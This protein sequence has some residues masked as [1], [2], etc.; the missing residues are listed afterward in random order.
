MNFE[1]TKIKEL[2]V[3]QKESFEEKKENLDMVKEILEASFG[4]DKLPKDLV[5]DMVNIRKDIRN[6]IEKEN[7]VEELDDLTDHRIKL[8]MADIY[9]PSFKNEEIK[10]ITEEADGDIEISFENGQKEKLGEG[11]KEL[12]FSL[13]VYFDSYRLALNAN[14]F[15]NNIEGIKDEIIQSNNDKKTNFYKEEEKTDEVVSKLKEKYIQAGFSEAELKELIKICD[16]KDL[17]SLPIHEINIMS[18]VNELFS[19]YMKGDKA[20]YVGLSVAL[21]AP[22]FIQGYAPM[23]L[24]NA[25]K[26]GTVDINQ[27]F[28]FALAAVGGSS[29]SFGI[30]K[31]YKDFINKNYKKEGGISEF[32]AK[33]L[34]EMPPDETKK[35]GLDTIKK[36]SERGRSSYENVLN[37]IGFDVLPTVTTLATSAVVL[38]EKS[39]I[40][41]GTTVL[42]S[43]I[44]IILNKYIEK[45]GKFWGRQRDSERA[46]EEMIK[47][48]NEQLNA[49]MEI[50]L[51]GEKE[52]FFEE[53]KEFMEKEKIAQGNSRYFEFLQDYLNG[54]TSVIN[55]TLG[56]LA[57]ALSGGSPDKVLAAILYSGNID[58]GLQRLMSSKRNLFRSLRNIMQME[59]MFNGYA[60]EEEGKEKGRIGIDQIKNGDIDLKNVNVELDSKKILDDISLNIPSGSMAYLEGA[61]G[62]GKTTLMKIISG[63]YRPTSGEVKFGEV[64]VENIKKTGEESIYNKIAYLSQFPYLFD[65]TLKN[66]LKFGL[67]KN[68]KITDDKIVEVLK[69]V[70]L[71]DRFGKN[72]DE[73]I[74]GGHGDLGKTSGGETSRI[75]LARVLLKIRNSDSKLVFLDEPTAS[76]DKTTKEE[77]AKIIN[78]EKIK[79]PET[80]FIVISHDTQFVEMLNCNI[81]VKMEKGKVIEE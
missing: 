69:D 4:K 32:T 8:L 33:N 29:I 21:M 53:I 44:T 80:T 38:Y 75:G 50:I 39:P 56:A 77:I 81:K 73:K 59:L 23:L 71:Y 2:K 58:R 24:A 51:A 78:N 22:A 17:D 14:K 26:G 74:F 20:K 5:L 47:K 68:V 66:N 18:K 1:K 49:H 40:L 3:T 48:M 31:N 19:R 36:R 42:A 43:G 10:E 72:L 62:A 37:T 11:E 9:N 41:A 12:L 13:R 25:F 64:P 7:F 76:V 52:K 30:Q 60:E 15:R 63:Y 28:L 70:G 65:N 57:G 55:L 34:T 6:E 54:I 46:S 27:I 35:F 16:L 79:R 67:N 61:S 45:V